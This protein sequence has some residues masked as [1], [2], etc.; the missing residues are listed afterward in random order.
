MGIQFY[1][2]AQNVANSVVRAFEAGNI[3]EALSQV[4]VQGAADKHIATYSYMNRLVVLLSGYSD[5]RGRK[6]WGKLDRTV[7]ASEMDN[8]VHIL[9][10]VMGYYKKENPKTGKMESRKW[11]KG[12]K[13]VQVYGLEQTEGKPLENAQ[14]VNE[15][16]SDLPFLNVAREWGIEIQAYNGNEHGARGYY[17]PLSG[18]IALGVKNLSTWAHELAHAAD[19][20]LGNLKKE[21]SRAIGEVVAEFAGAV[22]L[23]CIGREEEADLGGAFEYIKVWAGREDLSVADACY[24][25]VNRVCKIVE[26]VLETADE[27]EKA[28]A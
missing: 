8:P 4:F 18:D 9:A 11:L 25:V 13:V 24:K 6:Q 27:L 12:F 10:P 2:K 20:K 15:F 22:M 23:K 16:L 26:L 5:A 17:A 14:D 19:D 21:K 1:G 28:T 3:P 7:K